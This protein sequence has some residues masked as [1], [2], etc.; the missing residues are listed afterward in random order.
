MSAEFADMKDDLGPVYGGA[1]GER[2][3]P[4]IVTMMRAGRA[5][6]SIT[7]VQWQ[8]TRDALAAQLARYEQMT[9]SCRSCLFL[10]GSGWCAQWEA[11]PPAE[12]QASGCDRWEF[13]GVPF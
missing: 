12:F 7:R 11:K 1:E 13:D 6:Q 5:G 9:P 4:S 2:V 8:A 3:G 10:D